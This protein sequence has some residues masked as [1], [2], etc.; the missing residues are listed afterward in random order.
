MHLT[1]AVLPL[2]NSVL[3]ATPADTVFDKLKDTYSPV[4]LKYLAS[5]GFHFVHPA[6]LSSEIQ[7]QLPVLLQ[8]GFEVPLSGTLYNHLYEKGK[9]FP[10]LSINHIL[11]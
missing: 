1:D 8:Q 11:I 7:V 3:L 5:R 6:V 4:L 9:D 10:H 2:Y